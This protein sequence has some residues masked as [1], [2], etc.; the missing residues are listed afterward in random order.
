M[1]PADAA[2]RL[3]SAII[4]PEASIAEAIAQLE[5]AG[6]GA[7]LLC[8]PDRH[9][10][11]VLTDGDVRRAILAN[12][13]FERPCLEIANTNPVVA[14]ADVS[15]AEALELMDHAREFVLN[16]LPLLSH[17]GVVVG[18]LLRSDL[19]TPELLPLSAVIMAGGFG[20]RLLPLTEHTPKPMLP[21]GGRPLLERTIGRLRNAGIAR[22]AITTHHLADRI[23]THFGDGREFG[24]ELNYVAEDSPLGTAGALRLLGEMQEPM[25][26]INGDILTGLSF[27]DM[28]AFHRRHGAEMTVGVR[29]CDVEI[30]YGVLE[31]DG[32]FVRGV[33]EK[34]K[35]SVLINA[36]VYLLE[37]TVRRLIPDD[38]R[39]DMTDLMQRLL[40]ERRRVVSFPIVEYW[41]DI[42]QRADYEQAQQDIRVVGLER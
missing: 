8:D 7:L 13:P 20:K 10:R 31:C 16:H 11:G 37:P 41:L 1:L 30:P 34:P 33:R 26:V 39:F 12:I 2:R 9:L 42:G 5:H 21:V 24:V 18:F 35:T 17:D 40:E 27:R 14:P 23:T 3:E 25:L 4:R 22:V 38:R 19:S 6:T 36:G 15:P 28:L 32:P 29:R